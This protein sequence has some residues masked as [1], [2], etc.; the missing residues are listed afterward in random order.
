M[1]VRYCDASE[2]RRPAC[3]LFRSRLS[4]LGMIA[5]VSGSLGCR[6]V[7]PLWLG[8][9]NDA[10]TAASRSTTPSQ[11]V[12]EAVAVV[13]A[14][15]SPPQSPPARAVHATSP[16]TGEAANSPTEANTLIPPAFAAAAAAESASLPVTMPPTLPDVIPAAASAL[17]AALPAAAPLALPAAA[18]PAPALVAT[19]PPPT[20]SRFN[21]QETPSLNL[22]ASA[23]Q[24][25]AAQPPAPTT[26]ELEIA[27]VRPNGGV[28]KVAVFT[29]PE[30]FLN[31]TAA[32]QAFELP[33]SAQRVTA[34]LT[35]SDVC[36]IAVFQ[37][38]DGNGRLTTNRLGIP[39]EPCGFSNNV[40]IKRGPPSFADAAV[41]PGSPG[42]PK[43][44]R[45][46]LP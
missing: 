46:E 14:T 19:A 28:I 42:S 24:P 10:A 22:Q 11:S 23:S 31:P 20:E 5:L 1:R 41:Q 3:D 7:Q 44:V 27:N 43:A 40:V 18:K 29:S 21:Q 30:Q 16:A 25:T 17:P 12:P 32:A 8:R 33:P 35:L 9:N 39:S 37:D 36:A 45:I 4:V 38:M 13:P 6:S 34:S 15:A 26:I 2:P